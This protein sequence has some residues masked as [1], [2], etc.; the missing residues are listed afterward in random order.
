MKRSDLIVNLSSLNAQDL[1]FQS[2][3]NGGLNQMSF[4][5]APYFHKG[6]SRPSRWSYYSFLAVSEY[7]SLY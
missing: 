6:Q 4:G 2:S 7:G 5:A 1:H 3:P